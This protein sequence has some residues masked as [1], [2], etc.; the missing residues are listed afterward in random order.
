MNDIIDNDF[1]EKKSFDSELASYLS[2]NKYFPDLGY[3]AASVPG[4]MGAAAVQLDLFSELSPKQQT[5]LNKSDNAYMINRQGRRIVTTRVEKKLIYALSVWVSQYKDKPFF[6]NFVEQLHSEEKIKSNL[7]FP[8]DL[9]QFAKLMYGRNHPTQLQ[10][11]REILEKLSD[12]RQVIKIT[13][14]GKTATIVAPL[15]H[16]GDTVVLSSE[17]KLEPDIMQ[18][19]IIFGKLFF[20]DFFK[21][22]SCFPMRL[23]EIWNKKGSGTDSDLFD[24]LLETLLNHRWQHITAYNTAGKQLSTE[25]KRSG[26]DRLDKASFDKEVEKRKQAALYYREPMA[27]ILERTGKTYY[28]KQRK[29]GKLKEV[30]DSV[31]KALTGPYV[32]IIDYFH[33][34]EKTGDLIMRYNANYGNKNF[35]LEQKEELKQ[36]A[37]DGAHSANDGA[38]SANDGANP[39]NDGAK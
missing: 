23:F 33:Y 27:N 14:N 4:N 31:G 25:I 18:V 16:F 26:K 17:G 6:K 11:I 2:E 22:Y 20:I 30:L 38:H 28:I 12:M 21:R 3:V 13:R 9:K 10:S 7:E 1:Q 35:F 37:N 24:V 32:G 19:N 36:L 8:I 15:I 39:A 29:K 5:E 34:D